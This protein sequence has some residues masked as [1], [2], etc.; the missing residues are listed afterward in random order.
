MFWQSDDTS[1]QWTPFMSKFGL[2]YTMKP[3]P[4]RRLGTSIKDKALILKV[5][6]GMYTVMVHDPRMLPIRLN[7]L[8][9]LKAILSWNIKSCLSSIF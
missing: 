6:P 1:T 8:S 7:K 4:G 2:C 3:P 9:I 5:Q